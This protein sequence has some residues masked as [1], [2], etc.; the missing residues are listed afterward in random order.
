ML[1]INAVWQAFCPLLNS[2]ATNIKNGRPKFK[3]CAY[4]WYKCLTKSSARSPY[5]LAWILVVILYY[6]IMFSSIVCCQ[7]V[8]VWIIKY[9]PPNIWQCQV[10]DLICFR[11]SE[12]W[13]E[14]LINWEMQK[15]IVL[16]YTSVSIKQT[17]KYVGGSIF[18]RRF[19][20][21]WC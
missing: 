4:A 6:C 16:D 5:R 14:L 11:K 17:F 12:Q 21:E 19:S 15:Y 9:L 13:T 1:E 20:L 18:F 2:Q 7:K 10:S 8:T 3:L